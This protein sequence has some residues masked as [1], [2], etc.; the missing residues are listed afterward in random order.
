MTPDEDSDNASLLVSDIVRS[1]P[2]CRRRLT[3]GDNIIIG[4]QQAPSLQHSH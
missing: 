2:R 4:S 3:G 1:C